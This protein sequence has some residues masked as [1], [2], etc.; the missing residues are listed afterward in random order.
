VIA[1]VNQVYGDIGVTQWL[2]PLLLAPSMAVAGKLAV[3]SGAWPA[4]TPRRRPV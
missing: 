1:Y 3:L 4:P 2:G